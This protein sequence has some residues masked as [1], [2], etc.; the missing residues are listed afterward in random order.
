MDKIFVL[1]LTTSRDVPQKST[2][3]RQGWKHKNTVLCA[4]ANCGK[5][6]PEDYTVA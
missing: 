3:T 2:E 1:K 4:R 5:E 6:R